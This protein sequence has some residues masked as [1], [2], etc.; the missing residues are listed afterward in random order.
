MKLTLPTQC[1]LKWY[2]TFNKLWGIFIKKDPTRCNNVSKFYYSTFT[3]SSTCFG[4]HIAHHQEPNTALATSGFAHVEA[5]GR[6]VGGRCQ[7][8]C[9]W[10]RPPT[11]RPTTFR[12]CK[13]RG[14]QCSFRLL[15][16]GD[17]SPETCRASYKCGIIKFWH[18]VA[19][20]WIFIYKFYYDT[21]IHEHHV[22]NIVMFILGGTKR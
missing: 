15:M 19:S 11:T 14:C 7:P 6:V 17:V 10:Q 18:I 9:A 2:Y 20:C 22:G 16:M 3:W 12:V 1:G 5:F 4:R 21:R 13:T 8:H